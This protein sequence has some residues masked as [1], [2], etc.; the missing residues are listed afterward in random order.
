MFFLQ[1]EAIVWLW[2][3]NQPSCFP[4]TAR[5][6]SQPHYY[7]FSCCVE[8]GTQVEKIIIWSYLSLHFFLSGCGWYK[9]SRYVEE[10]VASAKAAVE[11][12]IRHGISLVDFVF[13]VIQYLQIERRTTVMIYEFTSIQVGNNTYYPINQSK[14]YNSLIPSPKKKRKKTIV[15]S[16]SVKIKILTCNLFIK[17]SYTVYLW[18]HITLR[19]RS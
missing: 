19:T 7:W 5:W 10:L 3:Q 8:A 11:E 18:L 16:Y 12:V 17:S 15:L 6:P 2:G 9:C 14:R 4:W 1:F 13:V